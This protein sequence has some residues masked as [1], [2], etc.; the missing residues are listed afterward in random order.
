MEKGLSLINQ[1][2]NQ[3]VVPPGLMTGEI[4]FPHSLNGVGVPPPRRLVPNPIRHTH[5]S[6]AVP[7]DGSVND[8]R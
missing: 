3:C 1:P 6:K 5:D 7:S 2:V 8:V 4:S